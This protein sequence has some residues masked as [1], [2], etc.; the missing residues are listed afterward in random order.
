MADWDGSI[1]EAL[2]PLRGTVETAL[3]LAIRG[4]E[5]FDATVDR[6]TL[7]VATHTDR[8]DQPAQLATVTQL[9]PRR[10]EGVSS[11]A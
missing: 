2:A 4:G 8:A 5:D 1:R 10:T 6:L 11:G 3:R 7:A 9:R